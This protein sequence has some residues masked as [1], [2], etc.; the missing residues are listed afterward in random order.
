VRYRNNAADPNSL[1]TT[2]TTSIFEH[3]RGEL[4]VGTL[5]A[6]G[7]LKSGP[8]SLSHKTVQ[9]ILVD[10]KGTVWAGTED[11]LGEFDEAAPRGSDSHSHG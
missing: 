3:S 2:Y 6:L 4:W 1:D 11:G 5:R 7:R 8:D 10:H 9:K